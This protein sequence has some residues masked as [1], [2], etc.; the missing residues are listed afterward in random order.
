[1]IF[2]K[3]ELKIKCIEDGKAHFIR[4]IDKFLRLQPLEKEDIKLEILMDKFIKMYKILLNKKNLDDFENYREA[5]YDF[6]DHLN[7]TSCNH[8]DMLAHIVANMLWKKVHPNENHKDF[9]DE[10]SEILHSYEDFQC[11]LIGWDEDDED[12]EKLPKI[13]I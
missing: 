12:D 5:G 7:N 13:D 3:R 2:E 11:H 10:V 4:F 9:F 8:Y 6:C 1:M